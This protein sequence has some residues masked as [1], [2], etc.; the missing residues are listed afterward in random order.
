M[1]EWRRRKARKV[2][3]GGWRGG[4]GERSGGGR[5]KPLP[6]WRA[7]PLTAHHYECP[8]PTHHKPGLEPKAP[9]PPT[10][11][12]RASQSQALIAQ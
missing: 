8:A 11:T 10:E 12:P 6:N 2:G 9:H 4:R 5:R 3:V 7:Q 1:S